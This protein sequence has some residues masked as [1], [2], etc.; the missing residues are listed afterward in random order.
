MYLHNTACLI[1]DKIFSGEGA[2]CGG[3]WYQSK[4]REAGSWAMSWS[5]PLS[6]KQ[7]CEGEGHCL[8]GYSPILLFSDPA[9]WST[10]KKSKNALTNV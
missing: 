2:K 4:E 8:P 10:E 3:F 6:R 9:I 5:R 7:A 1:L